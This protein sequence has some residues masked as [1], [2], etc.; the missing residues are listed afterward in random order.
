MQVKIIAQL[1]KN[2]KYSLEVSQEL[3]QAIYTAV[4]YNNPDL[5]ELSCK[6][7]QLIYNG[8]D[9]LSEETEYVD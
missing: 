1:S 2:P 8:K 6:L 5:R 9:L 7:H 3:L 4:H